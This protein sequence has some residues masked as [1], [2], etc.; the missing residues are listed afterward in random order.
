M[1]EQFTKVI[2]GIKIDPKIFTFKFRCNC[3]GECC[4]YGVY[5]DLKEQQQIMRLK[6]RLLPLFDESQ[7]KNADKW[8]EPPEK[9]EDFE[10]GV[11]VGTEVINGKCAFLN[12]NG[13]CTLQTLAINEGVDKWKYK[14]L[15]CILF[16]FTVYDG[17]LTIDDDHIDRLKTCNI[18]PVDDISIFDACR[19]EL[20]HF[21][22]P[23]G[24]KELEDYQKEYLSDF[25]ESEQVNES[26]K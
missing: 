7:S 20:L 9:D 23:D 8:F 24:Y 19:E 25:I 17:A 11:A 10:S 26:C 6:D 14:P 13:L 18:N 2:N 4:Y 12:K 21:F 22:G 16:P 15:Y 1:S 3:T 5:T